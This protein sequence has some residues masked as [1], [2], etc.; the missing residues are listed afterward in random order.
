[1]CQWLGMTTKND[2]IGPKWPQE[3]QDHRGTIW[4][5]R[6]SARSPVGYVLTQGGKVVA[7]YPDRR[8]DLEVLAEKG[9]RWRLKCAVATCVWCQEPRTFRVAVGS[10]AG[11]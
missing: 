5:V 8:R 7:T 3:W 4:L 1:M 11:R 6:R 10:G 9:S 2:T